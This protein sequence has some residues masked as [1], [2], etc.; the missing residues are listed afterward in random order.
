MRADIL[1][2]ERQPAA[3]SRGVRQ[4]LLDV[5]HRGIDLLLILLTLLLRLLTFR[6]CFR[7]HC[8]HLYFI[9]HM[10][11]GQDA[12]KVKT[13]RM[14]PKEYRVHPIVFLIVLIVFPLLCPLNGFT[15]GVH[16]YHNT[17]AHGDVEVNPKVW[18]D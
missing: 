17:S 6:F 3:R 5:F 10:C 12:A 13:K 7:C 18:T 8:H 14:H 15:E 16:K 1:H 4:E 2:L 11:L 9:L